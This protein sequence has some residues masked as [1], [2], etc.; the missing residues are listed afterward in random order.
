MNITPRLSTLALWVALLFAGGCL[1]QSQ[2]TLQTLILFFKLTEA[3]PQGAEF[4]AH[5][6]TYPNEVKLKGQFVRISGRLDPVPTATR[7]TVKAVGV[8]PDTG[9]QLH[10]FQATVNIGADGTFNAVKKFNKNIAAGTVQTITVEPANGDIPIDTEIGI[11]VDVTKKKADFTSANSCASGGDSDGDS[12]PDQSA[13]TVVQVL[14]NEF[15]PKSITI[16]PGD[17]VRWQLSGVG[18]SH[19]VTAMSGSF[20]SGFVFTS[21]G[22]FFER[23]FP[24]A[25]DGET[26]EYSC[27]THKECCEMQGSVRVGANAAPPSDG[28]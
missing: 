7:V 23:K 12:D 18:T 25:E 4:V 10:K 24:V 3:V 19:T 22:A 11:C 17:T 5:A 27:V 21:Q 2:G 14:D 1:L 15:S 13:V 8:D 9:K 28:Y 6:S 26:F 20:D 16:Q